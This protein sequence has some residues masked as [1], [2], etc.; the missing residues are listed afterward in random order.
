MYVIIRNLGWQ[1][2]TYSWR[3]RYVMEG[4]RFPYLLLEQQIFK[5][6]LKLTLNMKIGT[7]KV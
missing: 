2:A 5:Q 1:S 4:F 7:L 6:Q 3:P